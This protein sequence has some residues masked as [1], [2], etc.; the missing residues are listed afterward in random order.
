MVSITDYGAFV[1]LEKG[2]EGLIYISEMSW[3][4]HVRHPSKVV[5]IGDTVEAVVLKVDKEN[6]KISLSLKQT[7]TDPWETVNRGIFTLNR[8]LDRVTLRPL[9]RGYKKVTPGSVRG[10]APCDHDALN[11]LT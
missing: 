9:A 4:R 7:E 8:G 5:K 1:E 10:V 6:E 3:T 2:V 11:L